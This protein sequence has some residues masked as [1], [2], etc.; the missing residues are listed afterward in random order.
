MGGEGRERGGRSVV[1]FFLHNGERVPL[2]PAVG[3]EIKRR[4]SAAGIGME[5]QKMAGNE[6]PALRIT[7]RAFYSLVNTAHSGGG[8]EVGGG[9]WLLHHKQI[10]ERGT[11][12]WLTWTCRSP[13][14]KRWR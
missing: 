9:D 8:G 4:R 14:F 12:P 11:L 10:W 2:A 6:A 13:G 5:P 7:R 3:E 1:F